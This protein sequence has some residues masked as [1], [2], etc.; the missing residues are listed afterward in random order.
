MKRSVILLFLFFGVLLAAAGCSEAKGLD[1]D[2]ES[3]LKA[4]RA[5]MIEFVSKSCIPCK[6]R[7]VYYWSDGCHYLGGTNHS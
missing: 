2:L 5:I 6:K 3:A 1:G 7:S 4:N